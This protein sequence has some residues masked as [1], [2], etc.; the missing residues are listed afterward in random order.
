MALYYKEFEQFHM[1]ARDRKTEYAK[2]VWS[3]MPA[4]LRDGMDLVVLEQFGIDRAINLFT[5]TEFQSL[6]NQE[7]NYAYFNLNI[8]SASAKALTEELEDYIEQL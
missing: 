8:D 6:L 7:Y 4:E 1:R 3:V 2:A 5:S